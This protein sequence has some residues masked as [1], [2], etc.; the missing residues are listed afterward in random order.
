GPGDIVEP[1]RII[2]VAPPNAL[3][4][5]GSTGTPINPA[6]LPS[7]D[8]FNHQRAQMLS[9]DLSV[10]SSPAR[11][12]PDIE[13]KNQAIT[14]LIYLHADEPE[15]ADALV[16]EISFVTSRTAVR[17]FSRDAWHPC[18]AALKHLGSSATAACL[19]GLHKLDLDSLADGTDAPAYKADLMA[20]V[21]RSVE[22][23]DIAEFIFHREAGKESDPR[24]RALF[25]SLITK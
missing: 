14:E 22:G 23:D 6:L 12:D 15:A 9:H 20:R 7:L 5:T 17:E 16:N 25:E 10:L 18:Y 21:I 19:R 1:G 8:S 24:R 4:P 13:R 2:L 3:T 11:S